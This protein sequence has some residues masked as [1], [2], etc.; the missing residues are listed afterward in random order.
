MAKVDKYHFVGVA[1]V[2]MSSVAQA[3]VGAGHKV[4][5][6]DRGT[7][8][9]PEYGLRT[10][11]C[12]VERLRQDKP[13]LSGVLAKL[14]N[15]GVVLYPQD[16]TGVTGD[17]TGI[18]VSTAIEG[19]NPDLV[20]AIKLGIPVLHRS[21][22]LARL[23]EGKRCL[24]ITG[25]SGKSTVTGMIG[26]A[27]AE[28]GADPT[29][30]NGAPV[31]D[32][33]D[34]EHIGNIRLGASDF[35]VIEADESDRSLLNYHPDWAIITNVSA[36][37]F[38]VEEAEQLF[39]TF[40]ENVKEWTI[41]G[42]VDI[43]GADLNLRMKGAH[44]IENAMIVALACARFGYSESDIVKVLESFSG[45]HRR[46][47][48]VGISHD[49]TV[50]D[51]YAHNP[52]KIRALWK[53]AAEDAR[54]VLGV[55]RP[56]GYGPLRKLMKDLEKC[57]VEVCVGED[58][59]FVLPVYDAGG[60]ADRSIGADELVRL[61]LDKGINAEYVEEDTVVDKV[62]AAAGEGDIVLVMG[63]RDPNLSALARSIL[64]RIE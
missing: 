8:S 11:D 32:W 60:T 2:G 24:A 47:E 58:K 53:A 54:K 56:H 63:A 52:A 15:A 31:L 25:T 29:V 35:W 7:L 62:A 44:N 18:V 64:A 23:V 28:L 39:E 20:A 49:V 36:D 34:D 17:L 10:A 59:L 27:L 9:V 22:M 19:D 51:D 37:H 21:E 30:V 4:S 55:W 12:G 46:Y 13:G 40:R 1:G 33:M 41:D 3:A 5:G 48:V 6:S 42:P 50:V 43:C 57:F 26:W 14:E 61:L 45:I 16:G 38:S